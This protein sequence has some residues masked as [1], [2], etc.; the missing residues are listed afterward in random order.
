M[1]QGR[2][3]EATN[4][5]DMLGLFRNLAHKNH[6]A[7]TF[8]AAAGAALKNFPSTSY[9]VITSENDFTDPTVMIAGCSGFPTLFNGVVRISATTHRRA[10]MLY[11]KFSGQEAHVCFAP[12]GYGIH[13]PL[14]RWSG[15]GAT[16]GKNSHNYSSG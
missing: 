7:D 6:G 8:L 1:R 12:H 15:Q 4:G 14:R 9:F 3:P 16:H 2:T 13:H 11:G 5:F 10:T